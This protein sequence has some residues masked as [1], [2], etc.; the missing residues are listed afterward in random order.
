MVIKFQRVGTGGMIKCHAYGHM[1]SPLGLNIDRCIIDCLS[2]LHN[3][4]VIEVKRKLCKKKI[5]FV[6]SLTGE[7]GGYFGV[8]S[9]VFTKY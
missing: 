6:F 1:P 4:Q 2:M 5:V 8:C 9:S 3:T 7:R